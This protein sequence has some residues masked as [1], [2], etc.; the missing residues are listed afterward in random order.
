MKIALCIKQVP[1]T[2][3]I[4]WTENNTIQ[5]EGVESIINPFDVYAAELALKLKSKIKNTEITVFT[6]GPKQA[7][8][9]LKKVLAIGCDNAVLIS[10]KKFAGAD[11]YATG[12]TISKAINT[13][14]PD[15]DLII[16]GQFAVDGDTAQTGPNIA[17]FLDIPQVTY[18]KDFVEFSVDGL[19]LT[20]E[21]EDGIETVKV[22]LPA[23]ICALKQ[24]FEPRRPLINGIISA[25]K[26]NITI[27]SMEDI[28]LTPEQT[29][30]KGSPTY[31]S[32]AFRNLS[33]HNAEK[34]ILNVDD[35]VNLLKEKL[36]SLG[37]VNND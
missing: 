27:L 3:D 19:V 1:D 16:C 22:Q 2:T 11:T 18:V 15:F 6:M 30:L 29:G 10:D 21:M 8:D 23:L 17:N 26:K 5:R 32:R 28:G 31:V 13:A 20:R 36:I 35:S 33:S 9:M 7:E 24:D 34:F 25:A 37:V 12:L 14:Y 4:R